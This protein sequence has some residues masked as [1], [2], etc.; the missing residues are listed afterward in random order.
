MGGG[1]NVHRLLCILRD[2]CKVRL[3]RSLYLLLA[4]SRM[5]SLLKSFRVEL[6][7]GLICGNAKSQKT[8]A[9][10]RGANWWCPMPFKFPNDE[11]AKFR[12]GAEKVRVAMRQ[13]LFQ[14]TLFNI[15]KS[16]RIRRESILLTCPT[17]RPGAIHFFVNFDVFKSLYLSQ[18]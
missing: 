12:Q 2:S 16:G 10:K 18:N 13:T 4:P 3:L 14:C 7:L 17:Q 8:P 1:A 6:K 9:E 15:L 11:F 5:L